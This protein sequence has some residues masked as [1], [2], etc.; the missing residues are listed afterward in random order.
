MLTHKVKLDVYDAGAPD[1]ECTVMWTEGP[2]CLL[3]SK[4][5]DALVEA[6]TV[7]SVFLPKSSFYRFNVKMNPGHHS[8]P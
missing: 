3:V 7:K 6:N 2:S 5:E 8:P 1:A 4:V